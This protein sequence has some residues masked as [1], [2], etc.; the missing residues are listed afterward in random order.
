MI[1]RIKSTDQGEKM[2][3]KVIDIMSKKQPLFAT[4]KQN[5]GHVRTIFMNNKVSILPV[6]D[7][8]E[9]VVGVISHRDL[10]DQTNDELRVDTIMTAKVYTIPSYENVDIAARIMKKQ[11][12]HHL[13]VTH[14]KKLVGV[15]SSFD[16]LTLVENKRFVEKNPSTP[17]KAKGAH[18]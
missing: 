2:T 11:K 18:A 7:A 10:I 3:V 17:K 9:Y 8:D 12:I 1:E 5:I 6:I 14:E 4:V 13:I 16:L 15:V